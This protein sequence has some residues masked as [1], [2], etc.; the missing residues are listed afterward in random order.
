MRAFLDRHPAAPVIAVLLSC[1]FWGSM[2]Y[3]LRAIAAGDIE[4]AWGSALAYGLPGIPLI[5]I[6][7]WR[8][9]RLRAGGIAL[10]VTGAATAICNVLFAA[11]VVIGEVAIIIL[12][13]YLNPI[14][15]TLLERIVLKS[16]ISPLRWVAIALALAGLV[17]L[18]G[19]GSR[20]PVPAHLSEWF[21]LIAGLFWSIALIALRFCRDVSVFD[22]SVVQFLTALPAGLVILAI[23]GQIDLMPSISTLL[24]SA[25]WLL[26]LAVIWLLPALILSL[27]GAAR[28]SPGRAGM[29][30]MVEVLVGIVSAAWLAGETLSWQVALGGALILGA[31]ALDTLAPQEQ[32][33]KEDGA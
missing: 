8:W 30:M 14:W 33:R 25:D 9:R 19:M 17:T 13:F 23:I 24:A 11:G 26:A 15:T 32:A 28:M 4:G 3:P 2:W 7:L 16:P 10:F 12:L 29:L 20:W 5:P 22:K 1:L 18:T 31:S 6:A 21:G 27:W